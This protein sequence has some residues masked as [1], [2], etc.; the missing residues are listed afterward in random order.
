M[1]AAVGDDDVIPRAYRNGDELRRVH[2]RS[3]ARYGEL[4]V[5]REEQRWQ[6]RAVLLLDSRRSA[7]TGSGP[8]SSF[9]FAVSAAAS[10]GV[11]LA[12]QGL[13]GHLLTDSWPAGRVVDVRR[14]AARRA[15]RGQPV[16]KP[17]LRPDER[18][19]EHHRRRPARSDRR[20]AVRATR[21][22]RSR[23]PAGRAGRASPCYWPRPPG[24]A[25]PIGARPMARPAPA[26][27]TATAVRPPS[28]RFRPLA[29]ARHRAACRQPRLPPPRQCCGRPGGASSRSM[30]P[31]RLLSPG[32]TC[33]GSAPTPRTA[34]TCLIWG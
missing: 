32:S 30:R 25:S 16:P 28:L 2:W 29:T 9:E 19:A 3:T 7:H 22:G 24:P 8:S 20:A 31:H 5:R 6:D 17:R 33:Q 21:P 18:R 23:P 15:L 12:R 11:H 10:V 14:R 13:D 34:A 27:W 1:T 26:Q 4:M